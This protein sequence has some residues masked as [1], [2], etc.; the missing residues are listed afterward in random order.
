[1]LASMQDTKGKKIWSTGTYQEIEPQNKIVVTDSFAD[2][3]GNIVSMIFV[4]YLLVVQI[5]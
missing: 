1:M 3:K 2:E 4:F 5:F